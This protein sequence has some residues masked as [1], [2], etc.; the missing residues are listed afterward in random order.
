[1]ADIYDI[2]ISNPVYIIIAV[3]LF[4]FILLKLLKKTIKL[5]IVIITL[6]VI[7]I[8]FQYYVGQN[9]DGVNEK[10]GNKVEIV[11]QH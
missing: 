3:T 1:M 5:V 6:V 4:A 10:A 11:N 7:Y 9:V 8:A 2:I